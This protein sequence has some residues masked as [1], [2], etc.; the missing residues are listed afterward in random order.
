MCGRIART[1][2]HRMDEMPNK[3]DANQDRLAK[4]WRDMG[5]VWIPT[6][7]DKRIGFDGILA[8]RGKVWLVEIKDGSKP[9][10]QR[11]LTDNE[12]KRKV[13]L[14]CVGVQLYVIENEQ[15]ALALVGAT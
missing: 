14:N 4:M 3:V 5:A 1:H 8:F 15:Q 2:E 9:Q 13:Q 11:K 7:G 12:Q 6:S 10:S